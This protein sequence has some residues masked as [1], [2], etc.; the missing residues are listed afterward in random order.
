MGARSIASKIKLLLGADS[1]LL[2]L[3]DGQLFA[4]LE[5]EDT[6]VLR[7]INRSGAEFDMLCVPPNLSNLPTSN[8]GN[9]LYATLYGEKIWQP[10]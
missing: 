3:S 9:C 6:A 5:S 10:V 8:A 4:S 2:R 1:Q 7:L